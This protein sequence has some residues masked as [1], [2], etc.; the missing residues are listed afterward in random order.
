MI[1]HQQFA[2]FMFSLKE[3]L[4]KYAPELTEATIKA[5]FDAFA[6]VTYEDLV[7]V[8]RYCRDNMDHYPSIRVVKSLLARDDYDTPSDPFIELLN[9]VQTRNFE[10]H[11]TVLR[12]ARQLGGWSAIGDWKIEH[13][14]HKRRMI[15]PLWL[16][17]VQDWKVEEIKEDRKALPPANVMA[18]IEAGM[19]EG[20][21]E[22]AEKKKDENKLPPPSILGWLDEIRRE[23]PQSFRK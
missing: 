13:Y 1:N 4:P 12:L 6:E 17:I 8:Y 5:W 11:P 23:A 21:R 19:Q 22:A 9:A 16:K 7:G 3:I 2:R 14:D 18:V 15:E 20:Q 10:R